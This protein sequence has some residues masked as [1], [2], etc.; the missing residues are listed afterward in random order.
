LLALQFELI[1]DPCIIA[2]DEV[3]QLHQCFNIHPT[4]VIDLLISFLCE[5]VTLTLCIRLY[6]LHQKLQGFFQEL[7]HK[8]WS[9]SI[10]A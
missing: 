2:I 6:K 5:Y 1:I 3:R 9:K 8:S 4:L 7:E 10:V